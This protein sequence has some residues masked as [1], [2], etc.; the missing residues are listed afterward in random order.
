MFKLVGGTLSICAFC[1]LNVRVESHRRVNVLTP[2]R[3]THVSPNRCMVVRS[4][5]VVVQCC[6][7]VW[8]V[9]VLFFGLN[10]VW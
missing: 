9:D 7:F 8:F 6:A 4:N 1:K 10:V 3:R 5:F 2:P